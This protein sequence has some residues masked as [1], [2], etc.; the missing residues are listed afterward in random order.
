LLS[1]TSILGKLVNR[2]VNGNSR[3]GKSTGLL[4]YKAATLRGCYTN[5]AFL[6]RTDAPDVNLGDRTGVQTIDLM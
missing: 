2:L 6:A 5:D 4:H 3:L 1:T